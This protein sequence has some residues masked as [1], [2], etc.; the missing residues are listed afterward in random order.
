[1]VKKRNITTFD[2]NTGIKKNWLQ[3][4]NRKHRNRLPRI[5]KITNQQK[6]ENR[7]ETI[8]EISRHV[9]PE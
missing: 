2:Q 7:G 6:K 3:N 4:I 1:M 8:K 9:R 5:L